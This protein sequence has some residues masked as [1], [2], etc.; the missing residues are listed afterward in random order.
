MSSPTI[1]LASCGADGKLSFLF[2]V[3]DSAKN[4]I[5][6][7]T[8]AQAT[9][10]LQQELVQICWHLLFFHFL[11]MLNLNIDGCVISQGTAPAAL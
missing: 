2:T 6:P 9:R 3:A 10:L 4:A 7:A 1:R 11:F 5:A 8:A